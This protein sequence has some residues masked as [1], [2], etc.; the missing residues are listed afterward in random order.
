MK[1]YIAENKISYA[2]YGRMIG[3]CRASVCQWMKGKTMPSYKAIKKIEDIQ[4]GNS[5]L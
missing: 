2:E 3:Y 5:L 1:A 4:K